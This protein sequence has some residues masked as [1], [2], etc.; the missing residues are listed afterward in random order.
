MPCLR[1]VE[2]PQQ[3]ALSKEEYASY[4]KEGLLSQK[5]S[6][7]FA[8]GVLVKAHQLCQQCHTQGPEQSVRGFGIES[9][10]RIRNEVSLYS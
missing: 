6:S 3:N 5:R 1:S 2:T 4:S 10:L 7:P 8:M 9:L